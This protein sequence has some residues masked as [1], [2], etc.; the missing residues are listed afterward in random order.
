MLYNSLGARVNDWIDRPAEHT[1]LLPL[2]AEGRLIS[3][4]DLRS[5]TLLRLKTATA[6]VANHHAA[7]LVALTVG[8][9]LGLHVCPAAEGFYRQLES[10][11][12]PP[13][14]SNK[15]ISETSKG[16]VLKTEARVP[17]TDHKDVEEV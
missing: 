9:D 11:I 14:T 13:I 2:A 3:P 16:V 4:S 15:V 5:K 8:R 17:P 12:P 10:Q 1:S 7:H 6:K